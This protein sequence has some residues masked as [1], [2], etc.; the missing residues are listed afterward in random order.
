MILQKSLNEH[1]NGKWILILSLAS[2]L[3]SYYLADKQ[4]PNHTHHWILMTI[5]FTKFNSNCKCG[6][7][8]ETTIHFFLHCRDYSNQGKTLF[9]KS[10]N[11][12]R[13]LHNWNY[14]IIVEIPLFGSNGLNDE[15]NAWIIES[16]IEYIITKES[17]ITPLLSIHLS[18]SSH[19]FSLIDS[20]S[21]YIILSWCLINF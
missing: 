21:P 9:G 18:K 14:S 3:K 4:V 16:T 17:F 8:I 1:Y 6:W 10:S 2:K 20:G 15:K 13:S 5:P 11:I 7:H 12:T 19:L